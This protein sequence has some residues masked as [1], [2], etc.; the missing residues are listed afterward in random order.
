MYCYFGRS[1][2]FNSEF[3]INSDDYHPISEGSNTCLANFR[4]SARLP[5]PKNQ[6][7]LGNY[8]VV[9]QILGNDSPEY[10]EHLSE[11]TKEKPPIDCSSHDVGTLQYFDCVLGGNTHEIDHIIIEKD[12]SLYEN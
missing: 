11:V 10:Q 4:I 3:H 12:I 7:N 5:L 2:V 1:S 6:S 9:F 8:Q